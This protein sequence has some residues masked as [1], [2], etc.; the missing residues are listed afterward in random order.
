MT[1]IRTVT[2]SEKFSLVGFVCWQG[3]NCRSIKSCLRINKNTVQ[4]S[5]ERSARQGETINKKKYTI[6]I[7]KKTR[8]CYDSLRAFRTK[9]RYCRPGRTLP[10]VVHCQVKVERFQNMYLEQH[11]LFCV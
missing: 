3:R 5:Q 4:G 8:L 2:F 11:S 6:L 9:N 10:R 1:D 7:K